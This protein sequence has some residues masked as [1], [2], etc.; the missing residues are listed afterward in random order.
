MIEVGIDVVITVALVIFI[1]GITE[2]SYRI[3]YKSGANDV[4][5]QWKKTIKEM[6]DED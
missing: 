3:G 1:I 2:F 5:K 4:I 6:E